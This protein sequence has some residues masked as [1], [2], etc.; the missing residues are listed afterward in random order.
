MN[1]PDG[2]V[3]ID[4]MP[5]LQNR[6]RNF[7]QDLTPGAS[8]SLRRP[9]GPSTQAGRYQ[10]TT[11]NFQFLIDHAIRHSIRLRALGSNWSF[12]KVG[13]AGGGIVDTTKLEE[14][15]K[16]L[17][18][19][20]TSPDYLAKGGQAGNLVFTQ[21][22][23]G[24]LGLHQRLE[25][26]GKSL[27]ASG[28]SNGQT[29]VG[30]FST[31]THGS[32]FK[33]GSVHDTVVGI[34][35]ICGANR[36]I[37]L[38]RASNPVTSLAFTDWLG[39]ARENVRLDD[40]LFNAVVV[41]FGSFGF[42][43]G[44]L[45]EVEKLFLLEEYSNKRVAY[46][47]DLKRAMR[48]QEFAGTLAQALQLPVAPNP[49]ADEAYHFQM[50]VNPFQ[51]DPDSEDPAKGAYVRI[52]YKKPY[53]E[54]YVRRP[55]VSSQMKFSEDTLGLIQQLLNK[56]HAGQIPGAKR[57]IVNQLYDSALEDT[58]GT[59]GKVSELFGGT[60]VEGAAASMAIGVSATQ[61]PD[62]LNA[63]CRLNAQQPFLGV[64]GLRWVKQTPATLGFTRFPVTCVLELD[65]VEADDTRQFYQLVWDWLEKEGIPYTLHWGKINFS[66]N[67][68]RVRQMYTQEKVNS[69][70]RARHDLLDAPTRVVFT[71]EFM[72]QCGLAGAP[73]TSPLTPPAPIL[74]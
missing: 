15:S 7:T 52:L 39:V 23:T 68:D 50:I 8:F 36:H 48:T 9:T 11:A 34:H 46:N 53:A 4:N 21:C 20:M 17:T 27:R 37:W 60:D 47:A 26:L 61:S 66:L 56:L 65:G 19:A 55:G 10:Q 73:E 51:F 18:K 57:L 33:L 35:L 49:L 67:A 2:L 3:A 44:V 72:E 69:W 30:A 13:M 5:Q 16:V 24:I 70:L 74:V 64:L 22:G 59:A 43:H 71:N 41:G 12:T 63:I 32:A 6:H 14:I 28:A 40:D 42:I 25:P 31:G 1:L 45:L 58:N 62:V 54:P 38:E 29:I